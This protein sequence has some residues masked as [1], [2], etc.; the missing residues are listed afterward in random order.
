MVIG[1]SKKEYTLLNGN[2][3][4]H[5]INDIRPTSDGGF[6]CV[7]TLYP[8]A[9][10]TGFQDMWLLKIDSNGCADTACSLITGVSNTQNSIPTAWLYILI[11]LM[12]LLQ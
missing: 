10:D 9:P 7:G 1:C 3:S 12:A 11:L 8:G 2:G 5:L 6:I 4:D